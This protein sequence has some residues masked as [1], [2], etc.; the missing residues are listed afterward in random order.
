MPGGSQRVGERGEIL[1][2]LLDIDIQFRGIDLKAR[3]EFFPDL[4]RKL[5]EFDQVT[6]MC[7]DVRC[8]FRNDARL[9]RREKFEDESGAHGGI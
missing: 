5:A 6:V 2:E 1:L 8:D 9:V 3:K 4:I 7:R